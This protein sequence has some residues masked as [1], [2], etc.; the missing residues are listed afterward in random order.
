MIPMFTRMLVSLLLI[1]PASM[2]HS[3][4]WTEISVLAK[5]NPAFKVLDAP[6]RQNVLQRMRHVPRVG[7]V[8][9][10]IADSETG[11]YYHQ[12]DLTLQGPVDGDT[13]LIVDGTLRIQGLYDDYRNAIGQLVVLGDLHVDHLISWGTVA[14]TGSIKASGLV[15]PYYNDFTF[16][17]GGQIE[18]RA[19]VVH[20][21][22]TDFDPQ[23]LRV[24]Y[25]INDLGPINGV[26]PVRFFAPAVMLPNL[27]EFDFDG[28]F[29]E[30]TD[31]VFPDP[32][33]CRHAIHAG[34]ALFRNTLAPK[35]MIV[36]L[37]QLMSTDD[38]P[39]DLASLVK[40]DPLLLLAAACRSDL[41]PKDVDLL[42]ASGDKHVLSRLAESETVN[43]DQ[44]RRIAHAQ[45]A[46]I[47]AM[48]QN[49]QAP[50][51]LLVPLAKSNDELK[52]QL[53]VHRTDL[54]VEQ[55]GELAGDQN[56]RVRELVVNHPLA[57]G[58]PAEQLQQLSADPEPRV[59][60]AIAT[61]DG[62]ADFEL[63]K[64]LATDKDQLVRFETAKNL[65]DQFSW[66]RTRTLTE[67]QIHSLAE[68]LFADAE[69]QVS[70]RAVAA[71]SPERQHEA[72]K[73]W[74]DLVAG[75]PRYGAVIEDLAERTA[76]VS[77]MER[78][79][80]RGNLDTR[81]ALAR[82][83]SL[84]DAIQQKL[85]QLLPPATGR[86][87]ISLLDYDAVLAEA[88]S[89]DIVL[90]DLLR[91]PN[92]SPDAARAL[93]NYITTGGAP[94]ILSQAM[95]ERRDLPAE[96]L[97]MLGKVNDAEYLEEWAGT[98][99]RSA[100]ASQTTLQRALQL[101]DPD[102][103]ELLAS[104]R[105]LQRHQGDD[106]WRALAASDNAWLKESAAANQNTPANVLSQMWKDEP[107]DSDVRLACSAN[108][109][110]PMSEELMRDGYRAYLNPA[111]TTEQL[112]SILL[113]EALADNESYRVE[114]VRE[115]LAARRLRAW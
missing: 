20:D 58:L 66:K 62:V 55:L 96:L 88:E 31:C 34:E 24:Q 22:S 97:D 106:W 104:V 101:W 72:A 84:P 8:K 80:V 98:V 50:I 65:A 57:K 25:R 33:A 73:D 111:L 30:S 71:L 14:V 46:A 60:R 77:L 17:V 23:R 75:E 112:E 67:A 41:S 78:M 32:Q 113:R 56:A 35:S 86:R 105:K 64:R 100:R 82:N 59:R 49:P 45:P 47:A 10:I 9:E 103:D 2:L 36:D 68:Q 81:R 89:I 37:R 115:Q 16:E 52:Q 44:L 40:K 18:A 85:I 15:Y 26:E 5:D 70:L 76:S 13:N 90:A 83:L 74:F 53:L 51:E 39:V 38:K 48:V 61:A 94:R 87:R 63:L 19:L 54:P 42:I 99:L 6:T 110:M 3:Q 102:D 91:N 69:K 27:L 108:P 114:A 107:A 43:T 29:D 93:A 1:L 12:G 109:N 28:D 21:K 4:T 92:L 11:W 79:L 7:M 95:L